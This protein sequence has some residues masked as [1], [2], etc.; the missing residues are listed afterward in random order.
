[1]L[2]NARPSAQDGRRRRSPTPALPLRT[3]NFGARRRSHFRSKRATVA[4][5]N[6]RTSAQD[7]RLTKRLR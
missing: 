3:D 7:G 4:L 6:A 5:A 1:M 2:A